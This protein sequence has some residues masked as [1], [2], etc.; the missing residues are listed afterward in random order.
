MKVEEE[1]V[2][3]GETNFQLKVVYGEIEKDLC[4]NLFNCF[5]NIYGGCCSDGSKKLIPIFDGEKS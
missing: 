1:K 3:L 5:L 4:P 2:G